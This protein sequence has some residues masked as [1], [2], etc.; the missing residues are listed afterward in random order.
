[1]RIKRW[2][3]FSE[4]LDVFERNSRLFQ[5]SFSSDDD[6]SNLDF[7][8]WT[9]LTDIYEQ[10]DSY[11]FKI[12]LP[13]FTKEQISIDV[14][15]NMLTVKGERKQEDEI[16]NENCYRLERAYGQFQ[17]SF[18][19]PRNV[20]TGKIEAVL[21]DGVLKV[22]LPKTEEAKIKAIPISAK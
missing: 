7:A 12:D 21:T 13:G 4:M 18:T 22:S 20:D 1:M 6:R 17:R 14:N 5:D 15:N 19:V 11:V 8:S 10:K 3:P 2:Y 16:T 9:P